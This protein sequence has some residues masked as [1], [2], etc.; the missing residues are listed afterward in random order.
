MI[1]SLLKIHTQHSKKPSPIR[2]GLFVSLNR[3]TGRVPRAARRGGAALGAARIKGDTL[4]LEREY[5][6]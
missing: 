4:F 3:E 6:L 2:R 1:F 5:P